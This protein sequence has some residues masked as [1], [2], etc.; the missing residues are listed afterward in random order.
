MTVTLGEKRFLMD[1]SRKHSIQSAKP[2]KAVPAPNPI[3]HRRQQMYL[4]FCGESFY[5]SGGAND[6]VRRF[7]A[8][9][10]AEEYASNLIGRQ[11]VLMVNDWGGDL[12]DD[13]CEKV[14]WSHVFDTESMSIVQRFGR[15]PYGE[16]ED[17][18]GIIEIRD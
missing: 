7:D 14:E 2:A 13:Y 6:V 10:A 3:A 12:D 5:A 9:A 8:L 17:G 15:A 18:A 16:G 1:K 11:M 4:V